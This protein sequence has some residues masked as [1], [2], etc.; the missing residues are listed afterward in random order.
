MLKIFA[1]LAVFTVISLAGCAQG[2]TS[3]NVAEKVVQPAVVIDDMAVLD[4]GASRSWKLEPGNY[5][6][7]FSATGDGA[8]VE[9]A[10]SDCPKTKE[11]TKLSTTC[12]MKQTGQLVVTNAATIGAGDNVSV[13]VKVTR[14]VL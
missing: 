2:P 9:W 12:S 3:T 10:G 11:M 5:K 6:L 4:D 14:T 8:E 7:E 13:T 1:V